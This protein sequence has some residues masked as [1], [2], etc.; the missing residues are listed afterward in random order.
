[1]NLYRAKVMPQ[2]EM[3]HVSVPV[4]ELII[5]AET[6]KIA[7]KKIAHGGFVKFN[8]IVKVATTERYHPL[9]NQT[10]FVP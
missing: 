9:Y 5:A 6:L 10:R 4:I 8:E 2:E 3:K 1:M 7:E